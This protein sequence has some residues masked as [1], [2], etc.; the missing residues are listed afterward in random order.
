[1]TTSGSTDYNRTAI[2]IIR[3]AMRK[4]GALGEGETPSAEQIQNAM[5]AL[6]LMA[7]QWQAKGLNLW[8]K[9]E[10]ILWFVVGQQSYEMGLTGSD[11]VA[12]ISDTVITTLASD[13]ASGASVAVLTDSTGIEVDDILGINI[14]STEFHWSTVTSVSGS[15]V[16]F[17]DPITADA[18]SGNDVYA[19]T[20]IIPRPEQVPSV[21]IKYFTGTEVPLNINNRDQYFNLPNKDSTGKAN[22]IYYDP[23]LGVGVMYIWNVNDDLRDTLRFTYYRPIDDFDTLA[24]TPDYPQEWIHPLLWNLAVELAPEYG[25]GIDSSTMKLIKLTADESRNDVFGKD[26]DVSLYISPATRHRNV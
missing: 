3:G 6:N 8:V 10:A 11:R 2:Q 18:D 12:D 7:K 4:I 17:A 16:F 23:Q 21:R 19:Y 1:M 14:S 26:T 9:T 22:Q 20:N 24:N 15:S 25:R 5:E 13:V